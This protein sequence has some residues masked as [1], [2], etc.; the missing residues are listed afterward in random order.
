MAAQKNRPVPKPRSFHLQTK[1]SSEFSTTHLY[2]SAQDVL[3]KT[4]T[5]MWDAGFVQ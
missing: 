3:A 4:L 5:G 1:K 2:D